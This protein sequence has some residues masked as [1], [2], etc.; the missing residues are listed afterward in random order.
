MSAISSFTFAQ[1]FVVNPFFSEL[2]RILFIA[3]IFVPIFLSDPKLWCI[4]LQISPLAHF[5][6]LAKVEQI[7]NRS[8]TTS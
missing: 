4:H 8:G 6:K 7:L 3:V 1:V 5:R 2:P